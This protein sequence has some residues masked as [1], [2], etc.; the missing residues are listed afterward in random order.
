MNS[1]KSSLGN[2]GN[3]DDEQQ[4]PFRSWKK[5]YRNQN[6]L[7]LLVGKWLDV[8]SWYTCFW[9]RHRTF[10]SNWVGSELCLL[11]S[12]KA[13]WRKESSKSRQLASD[14]HWG[15]PPTTSSQEGGTRRPAGENNLCVSSVDRTFYSFYCQRSSF[16]LTHVASQP[17]VCWTVMFGDRRSWR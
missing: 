2:S 11:P 6:Y 7:V 3:I 13:L 12:W 14:Q 1:W 16:V 17:D 15:S 8:T 10:E 9:W 4:E 5:N